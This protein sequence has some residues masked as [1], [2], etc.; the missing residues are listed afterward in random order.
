[1]SAPTE[2]GPSYFSGY[3]ASRA[4]GREAQ[5]VSCVF[6]EVRGNFLATQYLGGPMRKTVAELVDTFLD[7]YHE[8]WD[9]Y[10]ALPVNPRA[11][12]NAGRFLDALNGLWP[13]PSVGVD[14]DGEMS[15]EWYRGPRLRFSIS[16][17][18]DATISYA[19]MF[20]SNT[21]HGTETFFD[22]VPTGILQ[23]LRRLYRMPA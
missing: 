23:N 9:G 22:E 3:D 1:M 20:G 4:E 21:V 16:I 13:Q 19:G 11:F 10:D 7:C 15:L 5:T 14:P 12:Q 6:N 17:G 8:N 2:S 18:P